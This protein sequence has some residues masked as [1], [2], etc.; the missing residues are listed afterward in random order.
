MQRALGQV[1]VVD[2]DTDIRTTVEDIL[3]EHYSVR[4]A[5]NGK[6][7]LELLSSL[8]GG[9]VVLLDLMMPVMDGWSFLD[10][11]ARRPRADT[12]VIVM[13]AAVDVSDVSGH[14]C[15]TGVLR[16]PFELARL[17]SHVRRAACEPALKFTET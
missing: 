2:D 7:A 13:S 12:P 5:A 15:V 6:D 11:L 1:L 14:A 3:S 4:S 8:S 17:L 9:C 16:K 10:A